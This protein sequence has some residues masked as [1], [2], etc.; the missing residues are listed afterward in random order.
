MRLQILA[1]AVCLLLAGPL[2]TA[3]AQS[4]AEI[5]SRVD[6]RQ[7]A[8]TEVAELT[9]TVFDNANDPGSSRSF[10]V[11]SYSRGPEEQVMFFRE[12]RRIAGMAILSRDEGQWVHFPSTGRVRRLSGAAKSR[13]VSG[14]GG[15][16]SYADLG[17]GTWGE[18]YRFTLRAESAESWTLE[19]LPRSDDVAYSRLVMS[20]RKKEYIAERIEFYEEGKDPQKILRVT[21]IRSFDG[22]REPARLVM[23]NP[24]ENS[25]TELVIHEIAYGTELD[26]SLFHPRRFYQ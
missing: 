3:A 24:A 18:D 14:V 5:I 13:S 6:A 25:R 1:A 10:R 2:L 7:S 4:A 21:E 16:F 26:D 9:M 17:S 11:Q 8:R 22:R 12:P 23:C 19:G 20:V 15:D